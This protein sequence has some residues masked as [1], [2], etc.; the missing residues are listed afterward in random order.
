MRRDYDREDTGR[1]STERIERGDQ[2]NEP[3]TGEKAEPKAPRDPRDSGVN[4]VRENRDRNS[5]D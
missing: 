5:G 4:I 2:F 1:K 3:R